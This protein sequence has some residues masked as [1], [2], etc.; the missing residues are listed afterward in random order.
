[1]ARAEAP[2]G[3]VYETDARA[4]SRVRVVGLFPE[5]SHQPITCPVALTPGANADAARFL[6]FIGSDAAR[7]LFERDGFAVLH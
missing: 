5:A 1:V 7:V 3:I 6:E 2:L 4:D